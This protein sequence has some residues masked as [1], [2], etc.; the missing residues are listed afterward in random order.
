MIELQK[1]DFVENSSKPKKAY[2]ALEAFIGRIVRVELD[3][4]SWGIE[5]TSGRFL[6]LSLSS[7]EIELSLEGF[8]R[9]EFDPTEDSLRFSVLQEDNG[10]WK[11]IYQSKDWGE[12]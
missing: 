6:G 2:R 8:D 10:M 3:Q 9:I 7:D 12:D 11:K 5:A 1:D 4:R